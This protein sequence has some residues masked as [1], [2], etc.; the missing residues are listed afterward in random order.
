VFLVLLIGKP[1]EPLPRYFHANSEDIGTAFHFVKHMRDQFKAQ[2]A[3]HR[4]LGKPGGKSIF[5]GTSDETSRRYEVIKVRIAG[6]ED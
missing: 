5:L 2:H 1:A 3:S 6:R 4:H